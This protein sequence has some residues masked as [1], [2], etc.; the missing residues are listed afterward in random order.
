MDRRKF[1]TTGIIASS[2]AML[3]NAQE[4]TA[5]TTGQQPENPAVHI[6]WL[7][8]ATML[9]TFNG[10]TILT[11]PCFGQGNKAFSMGDPNEMF[12][13]AKG[14]NII[15]HERLTPFVGLE[16][17]DINLMLLSHAHEDHFDQQAQA[18]LSPSLPMLVPSQ[19]KATITQKGFNLVED[20]P[21]KNTRTYKIKSGTIKIT[22]IPALHSEASSFSGI[23]GEGNGYWL[24][25]TQGNWRKTIYW[26]GDTFGT[27]IVLESLI[28]FGSPDVMIPHLGGVGTTG[29][30]GKISMEAKDLIPFVKAISPK[31]I[32]PIHHSTYPLYLEKISALSILNN[33]Y[34]LPLNLISEGT[35]ITY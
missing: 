20:L 6:R 30:L 15:D 31:S 16:T 24:E 8:A 12:D 3:L 23:L 13:L 19:E 22:S 27:P 2:A 34:G 10:F 33:E 5:S 26:T 7:G 29:P 14:P 4:S 9:I 11:D 18:T 1:L 28:P 32:L 17:S 21:W 25:F 35:V